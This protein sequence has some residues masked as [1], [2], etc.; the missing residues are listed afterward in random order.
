MVCFK[1]CGHH[2]NLYAHTTSSC[3]EEEVHTTN[4]CLVSDSVHCLLKPHKHCLYYNI[5]AIIMFPH[6]Q[7]SLL[8]PLL[9]FPRVN[10]FHSTEHYNASLPLI[11][12]IHAV[13][14]SASEWDRHPSTTRSFSCLTFDLSATHSAYRHCLV[15]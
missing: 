9:V 3:A 2:T 10:K 13:S 12:N 8:Q 14:A 6:L 5:T 11:V 4:E 15:L 7:T 1:E